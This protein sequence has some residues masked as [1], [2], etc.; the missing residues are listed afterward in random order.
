MGEAMQEAVAIVFC[1]FLL[2]SLCDV[3][4]SALGATFERSDSDGI[5]P[6]DRNGSWKTMADR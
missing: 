2:G 1:G 5:A 4:G 6:S 3:V